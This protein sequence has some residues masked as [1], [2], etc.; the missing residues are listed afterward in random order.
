MYSQ[1][2]AQGG[3]GDAEMMIDPALQ[4][5]RS[6]YI[7]VTSQSSGGG[8][9]WGSTVDL[10]QLGFDDTEMWEHDNWSEEGGVGQVDLFD[11]FF[12]GGGT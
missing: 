9:E 5:Q 12:F 4:Q 6:G 10:S 7:P 8:S 1:Q 2:S 3:G 11:R